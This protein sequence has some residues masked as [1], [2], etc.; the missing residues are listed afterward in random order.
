MRGHP[1]SASVPASWLRP[2]KRLCCLIAGA[3]LTG[4]DIDEGAACG[5]IG[6]KVAAFRVDHGLVKP[7]RDY[8]IDYQGHSVVL[9]GDT[10]PSENL[11]K[12]AQARTCWCMR[13][14]IRRRI[15]R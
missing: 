8:R 9:S 10:R 15:T 12:F 11:V 6:V 3:A 14:S 5:D 2:A 1:L 4:K 7:T 13:Y